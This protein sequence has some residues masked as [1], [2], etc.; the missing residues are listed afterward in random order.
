MIR[1]PASVRVLSLAILLAGGAEGVRAQSPTGSTPDPCTRASAGPRTASTDLYCMVLTAPLGLGRDVEARVDLRFAASPF[2]VAVTADGNVRYDATLTVRG[3][4][5]PGELGTDDAGRPYTTY[6]AWLTTPTFYPETRLQEVR[7]GVVELGRIA[8]DK[9]V[10]LVSAEVAPDVVE[11]SGRLVL[12]GQSPSTRMYPA[13]MMEYLVGAGGIDVGADPGGGMGGMHHV[14][15]G[16]G[17]LRPPMPEGITMLPA[18]MELEAPEAAPWLPGA[19]DPESIPWVRPRELVELAD[20]DTLALEATYVR[21]RL[22]GG[23]HIVYGFNGQIPG[24]LIQVHEA[25]TITVRFTNRIDWPTTVHWHGIRIDN[26][27]DGVPHLTQE[28]VAPGGSFTYTVHVPDAGIYWYHPH[29]REDIQKD[30]GLAGNLMVRPARADYYGPVHREEVVVLDDILMNGDALVPFGRERANDALMG[31]FGNLFL[32]NGEPEYRIEV[33]QGEV[34]RFFLTNVSN[35]RTFNLSFGGAPMKIVGSDIGLYERE[36]WTES[37]VLAPA[38]RAIV[39][40]RFPAAGELP[41]ENR[42]TGMDHLGGRFFPEVDRLGTVTVRHDVKLPDLA[43]PFT[44]L[45]EHLF[46]QEDIDRVRGEF[47]RPVD[48]ELL[49]TMEQEGLPFVVERLMRVDSAYFHPVEWSGTMPMMNWNATSA[50]V[51]WV[52]RDPATGREGMD[53]AWELP[54]GAVRKI[55]VHNERRAFHAMQ[56]PLHIHGQ[57]FLVLSVNGVPTDNLVWKDTV[58]VP[59]GATVDLLLEL[60]NPGAWMMHCHISEHL[61]AGM[62]SAFTVR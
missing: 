27:S 21:R 9:F 60:S 5:D 28:P 33:E 35:T 51:R 38:E 11:R 40:V 15:G 2:T 6:V 13:D 25:A 4:P 45:R 19:A 31:R 61:E 41:I 50:E 26:A 58:L 34:V 43:G 48:H 12:R 47:D 29:H 7:N 39:H 18:L 1:A 24:P 42:V 57:R 59:V 14:H 62:H 30:L 36:A 17:W 8:L 52:L 53:I 22:R 49:L 46:V 20:G 37:V 10:L 44:T 32:L 16:D 23:T 55:R 56:H 54:L 3:L